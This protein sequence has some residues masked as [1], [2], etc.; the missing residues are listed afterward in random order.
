MLF[1]T[2]GWNGEIWAEAEY[3]PPEVLEER[4][5]FEARA[6]PMKWTK[7]KQLVEARFAPEVIGRVQVQTTRYRYAHDHEGEFLVTIDGRKIYGSAYYQYW[8]ER[9]ALCDEHGGEPSSE[10][11]QEIER[12]LRE[13]GVA[14]HFDLHRAMFESL[15]QPL[16]AMLTNSRPL[17]RALG[18]LDA[19]C[20]KRRLAKL[21]D[22]SEHELVRCVFQLRQ[23]SGRGLLAS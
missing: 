20:G 11:V 5:D 4:A 7:L 13:R 8:K 21:D 15:N 14:D 22:A 3:K 2:F 6:F 18:I 1:Q 23:P 9:V 19:R 16:D 17:I 10:D 12:K